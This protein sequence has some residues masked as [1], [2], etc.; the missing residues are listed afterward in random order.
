MI[1]GADIALNHG[2]LVT[3]T[4]KVI[5]NYTD[6]LGMRSRADDLYQRAQQLLTFTPKRAT[7][8][9]DFDREMG[10]WGGKPS[11]ALLMTMLVSMY[12]ALA[13]NT[14]RTVVYATPSLLRYCVGAPLMSS[15][16][17][18]HDLVR[19]HAPTFVGDK[20]GDMLD[21]WLLAWAYKCIIQETTNVNDFTF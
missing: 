13:Q 1:I 20:H 4:G 17:E 12:G 5:F 9:I 14:R 10:S 8:V 7:I 3:D 16:K 2:A 6:G 15:K 21:A 18:V 19:E 11:V